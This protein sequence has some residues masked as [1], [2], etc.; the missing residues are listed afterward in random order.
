LLVSNASAAVLTA[1][2]IIYPYVSI[3]FDRYLQ[4]NP[5][6]CRSVFLSKLD[7]FLLKMTALPVSRALDKNLSNPG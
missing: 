3:C 6:A 5:L 7:Y 4:I 1:T 2:K